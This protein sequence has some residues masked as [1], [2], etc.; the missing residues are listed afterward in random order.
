M[1]MWR[2]IDSTTHLTLRTLRLRSF[3][4]SSSSSSSCSPANISFSTFTTIITHSHSHSHSHSFLPQ[5]HL[6]FTNTRHFTPNFAPFVLRCVSSV[7]TLDW[8]DAVSCSE[9]VVEGN[10]GA[11][12]Q[13]SKPSIPVRAFFFSTSVDL[14]SLVEQ[15][16]LN[17]VPPSSRMTNY[18]VLKFGNICDSKSKVLQREQNSPKKMM[19]LH[20]KTEKRRERLVAGL[21]RGRGS[22]M[23]KGV[24]ET[25]KIGMRKLNGI[26]TC[27]NH[28]T[29][30]R[31]AIPVLLGDH[32]AQ[33][34]TLVEIIVVNPNHE[35]D[36]LP[37]I[38]EDR[39]E[40]KLDEVVMNLLEKWQER[41]LSG[42]GC[43]VGAGSLM[44]I[45]LGC[46]NLARSRTGLLEKLGHQ[47]S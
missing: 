31:S 5:N 1:K 39:M 26:S 22:W 45:G 28:A 17:F 11:V 24:P 7:P 8:N 18:V 2:T 23:R 3:L 40:E 29:L 36:C 12:E 10:D 27:D 35:K 41:G 13:D 44:E 34:T 43:W 30:E 4:F 47:S 21:G 33:L 9:V 19:E 37:T 46:W 15:N 20:Q 32:Y 6:S 14:K 25:L 38:T 42:V 16:K